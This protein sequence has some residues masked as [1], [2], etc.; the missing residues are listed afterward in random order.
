MTVYLDTSTLVKLYLDEPDSDAVQQ[1]VSAA[2]IVATSVIA[3]AE[4]RATLARRRREGQITTGEL[5]E[6]RQQ[7][8]TDWAS[9][10][11]IDV[12]ETLA[13]AAGALAE[14]QA[15]RG[16]DAVHLASFERVLIGAEDDE[17]HFSCADERLS[18]AAKE[19]G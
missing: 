11:V 13:H 1:L 17:V 8:E 3:Y 7:F 6:V 10:L 4:V 15:L 9:F 2:D 5:A 16:C 12:G 14:T 18:R 19:L